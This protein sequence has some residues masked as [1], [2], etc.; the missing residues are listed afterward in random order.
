MYVWLLKSYH[1]S[2]CAGGVTHLG[3]FPQGGSSSSGWGGGL[4]VLLVSLV[5]GGTRTKG[6]ALLGLRR[7]LQGYV[8]AW[9]VR[10]PAELGVRC[11]SSS[12]V[13]I[14]CP[15]AVQ[16]RQS[17]GQKCGNANTLS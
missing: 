9:G 12:G 15:R 16:N 10:L 2:H 11:P 8:G 17:S 4:R 1:P 6:C 5:G 7:L 13:N 14:S 3:C